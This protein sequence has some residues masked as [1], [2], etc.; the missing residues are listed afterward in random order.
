MDIN[1]K[2]FL[3][4]FQATQK[5]RFFSVTAIGTHPCKLDALLALVS[6][7]FQSQFRFGFEGTA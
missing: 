5:G 3:H 4:S 6:N 1:N 7:H 2:D